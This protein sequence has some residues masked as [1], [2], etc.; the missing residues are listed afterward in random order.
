M[1]FIHSE[2]PSKKPKLDLPQ[3]LSQENDILSNPTHHVA[4]SIAAHYLAQTQPF[5]PTTT[6]NTVQQ[7]KTRL[8][9]PFGEMPDYEIKGSATIAS[10]IKPI[11]LKQLN[12]IFTPE[13]EVTQ[14][15]K[16]LVSISKISKLPLKEISSNISKPLLEEIISN[17]NQPE[18][19][20]LATEYF[21]EVLES[22]EGGLKGTLNLIRTS[23]IQPKAASLIL[24][25]KSIQ[26]IPHKTWLELNDSAKVHVGSKALYLSLSLQN[27]TNSNQCLE[28]IR[29]CLSALN[30]KIINSQYVV[31]KKH[32][33]MTDYCNIDDDPNEPND[34]FYEEV[35]FPLGYKHLPQ[36]E[37][38]TKQMHSINF[39][40]TKESFSLLADTCTELYSCEE[41]AASFLRLGKATLDTKI[42][43]KKILSKLSVLGFKQLQPHQMDQANTLVIFGNKDD[44]QPH[45][46]NHVTHYAVGLGNGLWASK[47]GK[48]NIYINPTLALEPKDYG[49]ILAVLL[50]TSQAPEQSAASIFERIRKSI[51]S[52]RKKDNY[53][54]DQWNEYR[55]KN[56]NCGLN[57][58]DDDSE[59]AVF[60]PVNWPPFIET[61]FYSDK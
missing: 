28:I 56:H 45:E 35:I 5:S 57:D 1:P 27:V 48:E 17:L 55:P 6:S 44:K 36:I 41:F 58:N 54:F 25:N 53:I 59:D 49:E 61:E 31:Y 29:F 16:L 10:H 33:I 20:Q 30:S 34:N 13:I 39:L 23:N 37:Q 9:T 32:L 26:R 24:L 52:C 8:V 7:Q 38:N 40:D 21:S 46:E 51:P 4:Q 18:T 15:C 14:F 11:D 50:K 43:L 3:G 19:Q 42:P 2:S 60:E 47:R 22:D 12:T